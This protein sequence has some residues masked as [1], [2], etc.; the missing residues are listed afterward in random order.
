MTARAST[1]VAAP[2]RAATATSAQ[3]AAAAG[4]SVHDGDLRRAGDL[5]QRKL[6]P[7]LYQLMAEHLLADGLRR[8]RRRP[9]A[10]SDDESFRDADA[11]GARTSDEIKRVR[12]RGSGS[13]FASGSSTSCG[14]STTPASLRRDR[15]S[16]STRSSDARRRRSAT[17][18][19]ISPCRRA[20]SSRSC[21]ICRR[22]GWRRGCHDPTQR[23]WARIVVEKPFGRSLETRARAERSRARAVRRAPDV[24]HRSLPRERR[25]SRTCWCCASPTRSSSR[26]GTGSGSTTCRSRRRRPSA[27]RQRGKYYEEAGVVRDMFQNHLLQLLALTAMEP[28]ARMTADAVRDEKVKVLKSIRW[29]TP[30]RSRTNAVRAQYAAGHDRREGG[31]GLREEPDVAPDSHDADVRRGALLRRQLAL[32]RRA[33]LSALRQAAGEARVGDRR[34]VPLAAAPDVRRPTGERDASRTRS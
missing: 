14:D 7:A 6:L 2:E 25:R 3:P 1:T 20:S 16:G 13:S 26:C 8:A 19:S 10:T 17:G 11:R 15:A 33:V 27:S 29:L 9:R 32:E 5:T 12:R 24:S 34:A 21:S 31:A 18:S 22:A 23:P 4:R 30:R 28:P